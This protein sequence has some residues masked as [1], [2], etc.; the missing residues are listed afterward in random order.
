[1][2]YP[3]QTPVVRFQSLDG[4]RGYAALVVFVY[5]IGDAYYPRTVSEDIAGPPTVMEASLSTVSKGAFAAI[6]N[7][8]FA[9]MV[10]YVLSGFVLTALMLTTRSTQL[11]L[12]YIS[13]R[14]LRLLPLTL[15]GALLGLVVVQS[16]Y[17][18]LT[19]LH[20][21]NC[22]TRLS[23]YPPPLRGL[24]EVLTFF[25][26]MLVDLWIG[27]EPPLYNTVLWTM[28]IEF[29][30]SIFLMLF[31]VG[32]SETRFRK[33][34]H[35][36][37]AVFGL[38]FVGKYYL[39]FSA[40]CYLADLWT[41][42]GFHCVMKNSLAGAFCGLVVMLCGAFDPDRGG[43]SEWI[44]RFI[45]IPLCRVI[46]YLCGGSAAVVMA[47]TAGFPSFLLSCKLSRFLGK[48]SFAFYVVHQPVIH[49]V[50][51][52]VLVKYAPHYGYDLA[53]LGGTVASLA[54][55]ISAAWLITEFIDIPTN[56]Y[57]KRLTEQWLGGTPL[58]K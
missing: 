19:S 20:E 8:R 24:G 41:R 11:R 30:A 9:V 13:Q 3:G 53:A 31:L 23:I 56:A 51:A 28:G 39:C 54:I 22:S 44:A 15:L 46:I 49:S 50:G 1:M 34:M 40:G 6:G 52:N 33:R 47:L 4:L 7:G 58:R 29:R 18:G 21:V 14:Y 16:G 32:Y 57:T 43:A 17:L 2:K 36:L 55:S 45:P 10:F 25:R 12:V 42:G 27:R 37:G 35:L 38:I 48:V 26:Q 5:H